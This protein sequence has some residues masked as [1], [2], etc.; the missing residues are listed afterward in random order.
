MDWQEWV[1]ATAATLVAVAVEETIRWKVKG[2]AGTI[3]G[4]V[5]G[6]AVRRWLRGDRDRLGSLAGVPGSRSLGLEP[7]KCPAEARPT[8]AP[9]LSWGSRK[10]RLP[11][12]PRR[13][14]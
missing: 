4:S 5:A 13:P 14:G 9:R 6:A 10:P 8:G 2:R 7:P 1:A 3:A 11:A 12:R